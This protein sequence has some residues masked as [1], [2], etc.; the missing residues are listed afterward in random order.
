[1]PGVRIDDRELMANLE[2]L[3]KAIQSALE[4][5][6]EVATELIEGEAVDRC[7]KKSTALSTSIQHGVEASASEIRGQVGTVLEYAPYVHEGTGLYAKNGNGRKTPWAYADESGVLHWT[8][9][10]HPNPFLQDAVDACRPQIL[11]CF[12]GVL[13]K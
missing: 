8:W 5:C 1:M 3:P 9:G 4:S 7:P 11:Q 2:N 6:M 10:Q 12:A 13:R